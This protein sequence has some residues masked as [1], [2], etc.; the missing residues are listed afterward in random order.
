MTLKSERQNHGQGDGLQSFIIPERL[1]AGKMGKCQVPSSALQAIGG[2]GF[3]AFLTFPLGHEYIR[4]AAH[5]WIT[6]GIRGKM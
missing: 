5:F 6:Q 4:E 2:W 1:P 3:P